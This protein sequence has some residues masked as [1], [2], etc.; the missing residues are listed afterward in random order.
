MTISKQVFTLIVKDSTK[1]NREGHPYDS[2]LEPVATEKQAAAYEESFARQEGEELEYQRRFNG[3]LNVNTWN[4]L[5][6]SCD[7][8]I[9][10]S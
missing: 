10:S 2:S 4:V 7:M 3:E 5:L 8:Q 1:D 6:I 9:S